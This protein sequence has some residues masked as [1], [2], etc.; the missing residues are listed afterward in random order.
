MTSLRYHELAGIGTDQVRDMLQLRAI[1][2][3]PSSISVVQHYEY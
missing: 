1:L 2:A 3:V